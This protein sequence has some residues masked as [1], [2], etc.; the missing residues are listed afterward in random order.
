[1]SRYIGSVCKLC[2]REKEK[3]FLKGDRCSTNCTLDRKRGK[4]IP[5]GGH[6]MSRVKVSDYARHLREKQK[7]RRLYFLTEE[8]FKHYFV[9]ADKMKGLTGENLL[10]LLELRLD[11]VVY[12]LGIV[13]S[14]KS[15]R[16]FIGHCKITVNGRKVNLP[17]YGLKAGDKVALKEKMKENVLVKKSLEKTDKVPSW[18]SLDKQNIV[19]TV[20]SVPN[21]EEFS[22]PIE[23][24]LIVELY[25]K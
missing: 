11:N 4:N 3:L 8:Q 15:A 24:Q 25:S 1:M 18:L 23:S 14:R 16:Q 10:R 5:G 9:R 19:G 2:R 6:G 21:P 20:V 12:R 17:G 22:H 13:N 7:A